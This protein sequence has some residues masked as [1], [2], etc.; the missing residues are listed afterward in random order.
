MSRRAGRPIFLTYNCASQQ[1]RE[2]G[3]MSIPSVEIA[4]AVADAA[5]QYAEEQWMQG[6]TDAV[7]E[8]WR[9][10][11]YDALV[12][13]VLHGI[14]LHETE[15]RRSALRWCSK[16]RAQLRI[17]NRR[18]VRCRTCGNVQAASPLATS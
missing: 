1:S 12:V 8:M 7:R 9:A 11:I 5:V 13:G 6:E 2:T 10:R 17:R 16:C 4:R 3:T 15:R 14:G 18:A